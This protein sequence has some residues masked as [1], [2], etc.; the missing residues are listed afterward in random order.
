MKGYYAPR[1]LPQI[2]KKENSQK[3]QGG[4]AQPDTEPPDRKKKKGKHPPQ[5]VPKFV[6]T[7]FKNVLESELQSLLSAASTEQTETMG[8]QP[9]S[10]TTT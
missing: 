7:F 9:V 1:D 5:V 10:A 2:L 4:D 6:V 8:S 3:K